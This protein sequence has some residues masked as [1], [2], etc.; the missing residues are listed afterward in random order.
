[1]PINKKS[2]WFRGLVIFIAGYIINT[3]FVYW[4]IGGVLRELSR[5]TVLGGLLLLII[6]A[7]V[8]MVKA[9]RK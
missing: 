2:L 3:A 4:E 8:K 6:G 5:I 9:I 1:M 7:I